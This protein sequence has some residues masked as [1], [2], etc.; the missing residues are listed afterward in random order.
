MLVNLLMIRNLVAASLAC[1][2]CTT[3]PAQAELLPADSAAIQRYVFDLRTRLGSSAG[4]PKSPDRPI[5]IPRSARP[6]APAEAKAA[7]RAAN[8]M[9]ERKRWWRVGLDPTTLDRPLREPASV[10]AGCTAAYRANLDDAARSLAI[11]KDA[12]EF[13]MWAQEQAGTGGFPFP[14]ARSTRSR[15]MAAAD[16]FFRRAEREGRLDQVIRQGW[17]VDDGDD[18]GLQFDNGEAGVAMFD[19]HAATKDPRHLASARKA[20]DWAVARPLV[21]NWNYNSFSVHL[22]AKAHA[23]TGELRYLA[24][25]TQKALLGVIP[26]QLKDGP[27]AGRWLDPHNA[28]PAYHYIMLRALAELGA[29]M[30]ADTAD[31]RAVMAA[32]E[33][34]LRARNSDFLG[35]GATNKNSAM[36]TLV[37]VNRLFAGQKGF[38]DATLSAQALERLGALV[39]EQYRQGNAPLDPKEWGLYL[40]F[41]AAR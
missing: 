33:L 11:A 15:A 10:I 9:I 32:L 36:E 24:A 3:A 8:D 27:N 35:P 25:A 18:G 38:L 5:A 34:G 20:A 23:A 1:V 31:R 4:V 14:S 17:A 12:A 19:L 39:A 7:F 28:Q 16:A 29:A 2:L 6:L 37:A 40:G 26:G 21:T 30:P 13:L 22:L 41:V